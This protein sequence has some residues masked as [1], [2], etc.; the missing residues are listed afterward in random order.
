M[1]Q[2][3]HRQKREGN[4]KK[5]RSR[6]TENDTSAQNEQPIHLAYFA[7]YVPPVHRQVYK[8]AVIP[9]KAGIQTKDVNTVFLDP[10]LRGGDEKIELV[11]GRTL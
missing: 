4:C 10:R 8:D 9:A 1:H 3:V 6:F 11:D 7:Y 2:S 5:N